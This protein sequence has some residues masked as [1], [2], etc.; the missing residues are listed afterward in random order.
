MELKLI[1]SGV[2]KGESYWGPQEDK[3]YF[4]LLYKPSN[5]NKRFDI[6]LRKSGNGN[7]AYYHYLVYNIVNDFEGRTG[8]YIG[9]TL[10]LDRYCKDYESILQSLDMIYRKVIL[11]KYL[12]VTNGNRVKYNFI[13][14]DDRDADNK[15]VEESIKSMLS[16]VL[17]NNDIVPIPSIP[18]G[19]NH[20]TFNVKEANPIDVANAVGQNGICSISDEFV[21]NRETTRLKEEFNNGAQSRQG[22]I[23]VLK[24]SIQSSEIKI[25]ELENECVR[26]KESSA[27]ER[28]SSGH[29]GNSHHHGSHHEHRSRKSKSGPW[30]IIACVL[31]ALALIVVSYGVFSSD[32]GKEVASVDAVDESQVDT[33]QNELTID[34]FLKQEESCPDAQIDIEGYSA[35]QGYSRGKEYA[36]TLKNVGEMPESI[37]VELVG[38][39]MVSKEASKIVFTPNEISDSVTM[40]FVNASVSPKQVIRRRVINVGK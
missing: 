38:A 1:L 36:A 3:Q 12:S 10:R 16:S 35:S 23:E 2:P 26:L 9:I 39:T 8:S 17:S 15:K 22:E 28:T 13:S 14:F 25:K 40:I 18:S 21:S 24:K 33:L 29:S 6:V 7:Y 20:L 27:S 32:S 34:D 37:C 11:G 4:G 30:A 19:R 5:E 31:S